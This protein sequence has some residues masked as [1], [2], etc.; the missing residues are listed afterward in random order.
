MVGRCVYMA[1]AKLHLI[2]IEEKYLATITR[3]LKEVFRNLIHLSPTTIKD[4]QNNTIDPGD[5]VILSSDILFGFASQFIPE[6]CPC[7]IAKRE[8]NYGNMKEV[9]DLPPGRNIL[10]VNDNWNNTKETV[11]SLRETFFEHNYFPYD[12]TKPFPSAIDYIITPDEVDL[13]PKGLGKV[14]DIG[15][16]LLDIEVF[17]EVKKLLSLEIESSTLYKRYTKSLI[18]LSKDHTFDESN[19]NKKII[20][21]VREVAGYHFSDMIAG[22]S[23]MKEPIRQAMTFSK[24]S[25]PIFLYG[26]AGTGKN[27]MAQAIH[28]DSQYKHGPFVVYHCGF[29]THD[30]LERELFGIENGHDVKM[31]LIERAHGGT[32][33]ITAINELPVFL[34]KR[35]VEVIETKKIMRVKGTSYVSVD[36][37]IIMSSTYSLDKLLNEGVIDQ[38]LAYLLSRSAVHMPS[39]SERKEDIEDLIENIKKRLHREDLTFTPRVMERLKNYRWK[40]N[41]KEL[42]N[43]ISY[44]SFLDKPIIDIHMLPLYIQGDKESFNQVLSSQEIQVDKIIEVIEEHGFIE[45]STAI[46]KAFHEGKRK[47]ES[48]GRLKL[49]DI[50]LKKEI[51]LTEQQLRMRL[52]VLQDLGLLNVRKG[53]AGTTISKL[54]EQFLECIGKGDESE[55][56]YFGRY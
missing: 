32:L 1:E 20:K 27:M 46:L 38:E 3:Q 30:V 33:Y 13:L 22:S 18:L 2:S 23:L 8:I 29:R 34:Q 10:V 14:I 7:I 16:R 26:E 44:L 43:T 55:T 48:Y 49:M 36:V 35:L 21:D 51:R 28:N 5:V 45:E 15:M 24:I 56:I 37:R 50:L 40:E 11:E 4:L 54:G 12:P 53:R 19:D 25:D 52:E 41:V 42:Y 17:F 9:I 47:R 6:G 31:G 39:L